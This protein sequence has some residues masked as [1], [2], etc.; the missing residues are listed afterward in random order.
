LRRGAIGDR[1]VVAYRLR[2]D[3][4]VA[5]GIRRVVRKQVDGAIDDLDRLAAGSGDEEELVHDVRKRTKMVR[6]AARLVREPLGAESTTANT[7]ARDAAHCLAGPREAQ[8]APK[9]LDRLLATVDAEERDALDALRAPLRDLAHRAAGTLTPDAIATARD[10]LDALHSRTS[11]WHFSHDGW[12]AIEPGLVRTYRRGRKRLAAA[13]AEPT[14][15]S[16]HELRKRV[17]DLWYHVRLL[18]DASPTTLRPLRDALHDLEDALGDDHDLWALTTT[19]Q[20]MVDVPGGSATVAMLE[21]RTSAARS[22]LER[23][24]FRLGERIYAERP[25]AFGRRIGAYVRAW[26]KDGAEVPVGPLEEVLEAPDPAR[27]HR[28][29]PAVA[30]SL[31]AVGVAAIAVVSIR[32][33]ATHRR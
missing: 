3:E 13:R 32:S 12:S 15:T 2:R 23:A 8:V 28:R 22:E 5:K 26:H 7:L 14:P 16:L 10:Q 1:D 25:A 29:R 19:V 17:K 6:A 18:E 31:V 20:R 27:V 33:L 11:H 4:R 21:R 24:A 9:T 30:R